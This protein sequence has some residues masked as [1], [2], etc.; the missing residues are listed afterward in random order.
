MIV[1]VSIHHKDSPDKEVLVYALLDDASDST[2]IKSETL[3]DLGL[4][5]PEVKLN[6]Y[7]MLG[8]E[9]ICVEKICGLIVKRMDKRVEIELPKLYSRASIPFQGNQIPTPEV[10]KKW[11]HLMNV[12]NK[13]QPY[14]SGKDVRIFIGCNCPRAIKPREV[15]LGKGDDPY[16]VKTLLGWEIIGPITP[17][18]E[19]QEAEELEPTM[20]HRIM[21]C[22]IGSNTPTSL[23]FISK[24]QLKEEINPHAVKK[25]FETDFSERNSSQEALWQEDRKFLSIVESGIHH[26]E[27]GHCEMPLPLRVPAPMLPS[28]CEVAL[29]R[30]IQLKWRFQSD[31]KYKDDYTAFMEKVISNGFA[32][33]V[34]P[35]EGEASGKA[36]PNQSEERQAWYIP[37]QCVLPEEAH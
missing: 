30:L 32:E 19:R 18:Q 9:E 31:R 22:E 25:M 16:A 12:A 8:K 10:V 2:F 29:R 3:H 5:G 28:N 23:S 36:G 33:K 15:V 21:S 17:H 4:K 27:D 20:C 14:Q 35:M 7:T 6:L 34:P 26:C 1:P 13:L 24:V 11:P 37:H